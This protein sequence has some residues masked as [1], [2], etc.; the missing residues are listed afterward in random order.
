MEDSEVVRYGY[1][2]EVKNPT[3]FMN[4]KK[5]LY[6]EGAFLIELMEHLDVLQL[7]TISDVKEL[8]FR[9]FILFGSN[10]ML[11][12][13]FLNGVLFEYRYLNKSDVLKD[14][15]GFKGSWENC[16]S[17]GVKYSLTTDFLKSIIGFQSRWRKGG[18]R[19]D[20][21]K[22]VGHLKLM[23][24]WSVFYGLRDFRF[25]T[26]EYSPRRDFLGQRGRVI[27]P[28]SHIT[29]AEQFSNFVIQEIK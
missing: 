25:F 24:E 18:S 29:S 7:K 3:L 23:G 10:Q 16:R 11:D 13:F 26:S 4:D 22:K 2:D 12:N 6:N 15:F 14:S 21:M 8:I 9:S 20:F 1:L 17:C 27:I 28:A 19:S 5:R